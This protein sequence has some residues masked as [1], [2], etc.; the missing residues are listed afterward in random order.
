MIPKSLKLTVYFWNNQ[1]FNQKL[2]V[3]DCY[4]VTGSI[5]KAYP[6][7][8]NVE[9]MKVPRVD[10]EVFQTLDMRHRNVDQAIQA[11]DELN[12]LSRGCV[13]TGLQQRGCR[14]RVGRTG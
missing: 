5:G 13:T 7:I 14:P 6:R 10:E 2:N 4:L 12:G 11:V 8:E 3:F 1:H 9:F